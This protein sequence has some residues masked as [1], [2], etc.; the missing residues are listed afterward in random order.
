MFICIIL[1]P[2]IINY[3][4]IKIGVYIFIKMCIRDSLYIH[5]AIETASLTK[6]EQDELPKKV[7]NIIESKLSK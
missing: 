6:E 2:C 3:R 1:S 7:Q 5:P 4:L